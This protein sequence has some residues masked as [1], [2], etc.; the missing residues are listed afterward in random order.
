MPAPGSFIDVL[1]RRL[2][3]DWDIHRVYNQYHLFS[4]PSHLK[5]ALIRYIG[6]AAEQGVSVADLKTILLP[7][8]EACDDQE[9]G[10]EYTWNSEV[11]CL[12][13]SGSIGPSLQP[14]DVSRLLFPPNPGAGPEPIKDS[15]DAADPA[16]GPPRVLLPNL[17]HLSLALDPTAGRDA[18]WNQL[19]ALSS[20]LSAVTHL[21]LAFWPAPCRNRALQQWSVAPLQGPG[22]SE[23]GAHESTDGDWSE[24]LL[25]L[26]QLSRKLYRLE[27]LDLTGCASWFEA[28]K[29]ENEHVSIDWVGAWGK[30]GVLRLRAGW[31]PGEDAQA[32]ERLAHAE[33]IKMARSIERHIIT[34]RA[35]KAMLITV[36]HDGE[37]L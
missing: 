35:G 8:A 16:P 9:P 25:V 23:A 11:S 5:P 12:D 4:L 2:A 17:T 24:A 20:K 29:L 10:R 6:V 36:E 34:K 30:V 21:S 14:R 3:L 32:W 31:T 27:Y 13:L 7:P 18:S 15:W 33:A 1:L 22:S 37:A 19:L 28:L 26:R